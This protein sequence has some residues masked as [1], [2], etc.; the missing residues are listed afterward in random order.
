MPFA[1]PL[2]QRVVTPMSQ[3]RHLV[4][5]VDPM[6]QSPR[7]AVRDHHHV[8]PAGGADPKPPAPLPGDRT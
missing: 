4:Q 8:A 3:Q 7:K 6:R 2:T 1:H 5:I